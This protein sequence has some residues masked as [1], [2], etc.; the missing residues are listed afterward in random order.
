MNKP[1]SE[2]L[3]RKYKIWQ[4]GSFTME[5]VS[6]FM[7]YLIMGIMNFDEW[8]TEESGWKVGLGGALGMALA[9]MA[10]LLVNKKHEADTKREAGEKPS[11]AVVTYEWITLILGWFLVMFIFL[12][13]ESILSQIVTIMFWGGVGLLSALGFDITSTEMKKKANEIKDATEEVRKEQLKEQIRK[14][15]HPIE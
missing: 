13:L 8:F 4:Y 15:Y 7:P 3:K 9:G 10:I 6:V 5:F 2:Q 11:T 14:E 1:T 12:L